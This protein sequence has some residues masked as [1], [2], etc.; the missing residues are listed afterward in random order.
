MKDLVLAK[1]GGSSLKDAN[2]FKRLI[3]L[4]ENKPNIRAVVISAT[5]NT[6]N[7]LEELA[8]KALARDFLGTVDALKK[9]KDKHQSIAQNLE[10]DFSVEEL[11]LKAQTHALNILRPEKK[12]PAIMDE[13]YSIGELLSANLF[14]AF[15]KKSF[16]ERSNFGNAKPLPG[17][18]KER[19]DR[20]LKPLLN[21]SSLV[22]IPGFI[23]SNL[24]NQT[25]T[26]GREGSDLSAAL[27]AS[28]LNVDELHI[29][30]DVAG[31]YSADP[32]L[33]ENARP[34]KQLSFSCANTLS[35]FGAK[36]LFPSALNP[37]MD[38]NIKVFIGSS[39]DSSVGTEIIKGESGHKFSGITLRN[40]FCRVDLQPLNKNN[41]PQNFK[42]NILKILA[43]K[44]IFPENI[45][46]NENSV[47]LILPAKAHIPR[48]HLREFCGVSQENQVSM[49]TIVGPAINEDIMTKA[50]QKLLDEKISLAKVD[51]GENYLTY[52]FPSRFEQK[53][54]NDL[55]HILFS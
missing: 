29:Y 3:G 9:L 21:D 44:D 51:I 42:E 45:L 37:V 41:T 11:V 8:T 54:L 26:L 53:V 31:I 55:H 17:E 50:V 38:K 18:I 32:K 22:I 23:G 28:A 40:S 1:I 43:E 15:L 30:K 33:V 7:L 5:F 19:V 27:L 24:K 47:T 36:V 35:E 6:T 16:P 14:A 25:T 48:D 46:S 2:S 34:I 20:K 39:T 52:A 12:C 13:L 4:F 49:A 10:I